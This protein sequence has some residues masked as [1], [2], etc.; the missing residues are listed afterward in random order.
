MVHKYLFKAFHN[1]TNKKEYDLQIW[2]HNVR[3]TNIIVMKNITILEKVRKKKVLLVGILD[4]TASTEMSQT[5]SLIDFAEKYNWAMNN[6]D[7]DAVE[8]LRRTSIKKYWRRDGQIKIKFDCLYNWIL[9]LAIF[10]KHLYRVYE[11]KLVM[12]NIKIRQ[13][14]D[15]E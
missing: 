2:E 1:K 12:D 13:N 15:S 7:L 5:S 14:I 10:V 4:T 9:I 11:N 6:A 3:Y 8:K